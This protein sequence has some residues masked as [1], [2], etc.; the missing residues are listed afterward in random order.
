MA[1]ERGLRSSPEPAQCEPQRASANQVKSKIS[2]LPDC[3]L[4]TEKLDACSEAAARSGFFCRPGSRAATEKTPKKNSQCTYVLYLARIELLYTY[5]DVVFYR[6][7]EFP[8]P[9]SRNAQ[10]RTKK[11]R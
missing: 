10:K 5:D 8:L 3:Q 2:A 7:F 4:R 1:V 6:V 11:N 9:L